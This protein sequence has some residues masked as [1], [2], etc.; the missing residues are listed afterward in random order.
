MTLAA[1]PA[2]VLFIIGHVVSL[3]ECAT[4]PLP[5]DI[6]DDRMRVAVHA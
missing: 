2:P 4:I 5:H 1:L 3:Y 6:C